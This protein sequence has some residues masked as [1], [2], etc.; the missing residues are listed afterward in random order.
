MDRIKVQLPHL[1]VGDLL[2]Y[3]FHPSS[4]TE[5]TEKLDMGKG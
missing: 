1:H 2:I 3:L 4:P 5:K